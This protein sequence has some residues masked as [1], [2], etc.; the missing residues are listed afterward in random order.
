M[1]IIYRHVKFYIPSF[2]G[3]SITAFRQ[4]TKQKL[5]NG[6]HYVVILFKIITVIFIS[7]FSK[8]C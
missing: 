4:T 5:S 2:N 1:F 7:Y 6:R 8:V 3:P